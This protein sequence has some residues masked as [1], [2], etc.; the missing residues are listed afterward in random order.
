MSDEEKEEER[1]KWRITIK[2]KEEK[3]ENYRREREGGREKGE[4]LSTKIYG[5]KVTIS[6]CVDIFVRKKYNF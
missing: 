5:G 6:R 4:M 2:E 3:K 1:C